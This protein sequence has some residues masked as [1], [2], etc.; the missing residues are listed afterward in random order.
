[1]GEGRTSFILKTCFCGGAFTVEKE[2]CDSFSCWP[3]ISTSPEVFNLRFILGSWHGGQGG[4][5]FG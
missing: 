5:G 3:S 2:N 1:M 4:G